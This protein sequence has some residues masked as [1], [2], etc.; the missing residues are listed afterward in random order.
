VTDAIGRKRHGAREVVAGLGEMP[1]TR[2]AVAQIVMDR[3]IV[4]GGGSDPQAEPERLLILAHPLD[5]RQSSVS[6]ESRMPERLLI[7]A[8]PFEPL[9]ARGAPGAH[10]GEPSQ[11]TGEVQLL[12]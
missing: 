11:L 6:R 10:G 3:G 2:F 7:L 1:L 12:E 9:R 4:R 5:L 8:H